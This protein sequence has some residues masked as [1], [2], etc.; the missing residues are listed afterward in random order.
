[1]SE[2]KSIETGKKT[3]SIRKTAKL[4]KASRSSVRK[5]AERYKQEEGLRDLSRRPGRSLLRALRK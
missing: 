4:W 5:W 3:N 1:L 2:E